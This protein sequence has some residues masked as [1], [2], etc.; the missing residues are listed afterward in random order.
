M[1]EVLVLAACLE[2]SEGCSKLSDHYFKYKGYD[3]IYDAFT[4]KY[5]RELEFVSPGI[6]MANVA[7]SGMIKVKY[8]PFVF[9]VKQ[10]EFKTTFTYDF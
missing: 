8:R 5:R 1:L 7:T 2:T 4:K 10:N 3:Q 6:F 9:E